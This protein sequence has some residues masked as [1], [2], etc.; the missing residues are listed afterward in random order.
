MSHAD[1]LALLEAAALM[2]GRVRALL[3]GDTEE[4]AA[5]QH[6]L[7]GCGACR[8]E[9]GAWQAVDEALVAV[10]PD[11]LPAPAA[12]KA[13]ILANVVATGVARGP[14]RILGAPRPALSAAGG[15]GGVAA[16]TDGA[17]ASS[18]S[19]TAPHAAAPADADAPPAPNAGRVWRTPGGAPMPSPMPV[20]VPAGTAAPGAPLPGDHAPAAPAAPA[21]PVG[22]AANAHPGDRAAV[23]TPEGAAVPPGRRGLRVL[24]GGRDGEGVGFR[25]FLAVAAAAVFLF[26]LGAALGGPLG[27]SSP[28]A[29]TDTAARV[30]LEKILGRMSDLLQVPGAIDNW[31]PLTDMDGEPAGAVVLGLP[32]TNLLGV[33]T[34]ALTP[35]PDD[36]RYLCILEREGERYEIGYM[37]FAADPDAEGDVAYWVGPLGEDVPLNAGLPGDVFTVFVEGQTSGPPLLSAVF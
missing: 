20:P 15:V 13:R 11:P 8:R 5:L 23:G 25:V 14:D 19:P 28:Q 10:A 37:R 6:H 26:A 16:G 21:G 4:S 3:S 1:V 7:D 24:A 31:A 2:P 35:L 30:E 34:R 9:A 27:L 12:A 17:A 33:V 36:G 22:P 18:D 32:E 29:V